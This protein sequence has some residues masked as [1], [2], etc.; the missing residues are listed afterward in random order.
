MNFLKIN[1]NQKPKT[2]VEKI[3]YYNHLKFFSNILIEFEYFQVFS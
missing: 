1:N 3:F 2:T